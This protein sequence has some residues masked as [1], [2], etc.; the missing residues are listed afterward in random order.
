MAKGGGAG[1]VYFVLYLAVVLELLIII[2]ER[3]EAEEGLL[4]KQKETQRIVESILSQLQSGAGTEG[5]NTRP[6]DEIT[7]PPSDIN[8]KEV[9]GIEIKPSRTYIVEVGVT[10]ITADIKR[11]TEA[12]E[13]EKDY[14]KRLRDLVKLCNVEEIEYQI[15]FNPSTDAFNAPIFLSDS[16]IKQRK[17]KFE[18]MA[19]GTVIDEQGWKF[20]SYRK[21]KFDLDATYDKIFNTDL[22]TLNSES[23]VPLY[24]ADK[25]VAN[26]NP[27]VSRGLSPDSAFFYSEVHTRMKAGSGTG[28]LKKRAFVVNFEPDNANQGWYK[29]RFSSRTNR[30]LGVA[31]EQK[32][33]QMDEQ[34]KVN[35][36]TVQLTV[37][38]LNRVLRDLIGKL[39]KFG[40]PSVD[41]LF[42]E[43]DIDKFEASLKE[44]EYK[45]AQGDNASELVSK[46]R[47][48]GYIAKLLAPGQSIN[49]A[50]NKGT[51]EFNIRVIKPTIPS[52]NVEIIANDVYPSF[53]QAD[54]I[55]EFTVSGYKPEMSRS[56]KA[57]LR[58]ENGAMLSN[59][60]TFQEAGTIT[61]TATQPG[62]QS[63]QTKIRAFLGKTPPVTQGISNKYKL[64]IEISGTRAAGETTLEVFPSKLANEQEFD[65]SLINQAYYGKSLELIGIPTSGKMMK[66][67]EFKTNVI[68]NS[69]KSVSIDGLRIEGK[70]FKFTPD[71]DNYAL[72]VLW[73]QPY[74]DGKTVEIFSRKDIPVRLDQARFDTRNSV[75]PSFVGNESRITGTISNIYIYKPL[76]DED[77]GVYAQVKVDV[78]EQKF[79]PS[80]SSNYSANAKAR[81]ISGDASTSYDVWEVFVELSGSLAE[82]EEF[83]SGNL[84]VTLVATA[85]AVKQS[86]VKVESTQNSPKLNYRINVSPQREEIQQSP[87]NRRRRR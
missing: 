75:P 71:V 37:R 58:D 18:D 56:L 79:T 43:G 67:N 17:L 16:A 65:N 68:T 86:N 35:I 76:M 52:A 28:D 69:Q 8:I 54:H 34:T 66:S 57:T 26:G 23:I 49:F 22:K 82:G 55:V 59:N 45:A 63:T 6:Q 5:I 25:I 42:K 64:N 2:V 15:F 40:L 3:D 53:D 30:I 21:L 27:Y 51:I 62:R 84:S 1:K 29:L 11:K 33:D 50:Q 77:R 80:G 24:P 85:S 12:G 78:S 81:K 46:V 9:L 83:V 20:L 72:Q 13:S 32:Q 19:P 14:Y 44:C 4:Q 73:V 48:Y 47:L 41:I 74:S 39:E 61:A 36:G 60:I 31:A 87:D 7:I 38:D 10:D 70:T